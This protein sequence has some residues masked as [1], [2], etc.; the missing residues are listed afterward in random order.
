MTVEVLTEEQLEELAAYLKGTATTLEDGLQ[1]LGMNVRRAFHAAIQES[2][3][4]VE[5]IDRCSVCNY[6][7]FSEAFQED[8]S[9]ELICFDCFRSDNE[10]EEW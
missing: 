6:W 4:D 1:E 10:F 9:G 7:T 5:G 3:T 2:L 8:D